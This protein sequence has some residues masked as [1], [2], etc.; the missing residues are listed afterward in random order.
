[1]SH[2]E[3]VRDTAEFG[4]L[5]MAWVL[6]AVLPGA[7]L[8]QVLA[9]AH[10][11]RRPAVAVGV[12][13]VMLAVAIWVVP[14]IRADGLTGREAAA[15]VM[16]AVAAVVIVGLDHRAHYA[17]RRADL[18]ILG[19]AWL[20][21]LV[22]L[23]RP[24]RAWISG[25]LV[26]LAAH[27]VLVIRAGGANKLSL[28]QLEAGGYILAAF[29]V[30]FAAL[31]PT[32]ALHTTITTRRAR[33]ASRSAAERAAAAAVLADRRSRRAVLEMEV[34]PLLRGIADGT[35][36]PAA[37]QVRER[38][39]RQAAV[40]RHSLTDTDRAPGTGELMAGL[41]PAVRAASAR[42][43]LVNVQ[44]IGDPGIAE[45]QV[46]RAVL[47]AL[48]AVI[49]ALPPHQVVLT[50]LASGDDVELYLTFSEPFRRSPAPDV[51]RFGR[52]VP[53]AA[54]WHATVDA[55]ETGPGCLEIGWRKAGAA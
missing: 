5:R 23:S 41:E 45:P 26:V 3:V 50:V 36:D 49:G 46:A 13:L 27:T 54:R 2:H 52:D 37:G 39:A 21:A 53:A 25:A 48:D 22:A 30:A 10:D 19:T 33:L 12:W 43:L 29:L 7:A 44:V 16:I 15:A 32:L 38:C 14:R 31:R 4:V 55:G 35:L 51:T 17:P 20:L 9:N 28:A 34:L 11:Y 1:V 8:V 18:A 40:L 24:P 6:A 47:A 42:G